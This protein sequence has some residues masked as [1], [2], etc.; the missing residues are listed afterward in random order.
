MVSV[1][2]IKAKDTYEIR[3]EILRKGVDLP[4]KLQGDLE[5]STFHLGAFIDDKLVAV[6]T[7]MKTEN[8]LFDTAQYQLRGMA[9]LDEYTYN[10]CGRKMLLFAE[11]LLKEMG[12]KV[13]WFNAREVAL[14]FY[15]KLGFQTK[16]DSFDIPLI[17]KHYL[18]YKEL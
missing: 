4:I 6:S 12:P 7:Y 11:Q 16:G 5:E 3:Q 17:G 15:L 18:M 1:K 9:T 2:K 10:G 14:D 13:L 8:S